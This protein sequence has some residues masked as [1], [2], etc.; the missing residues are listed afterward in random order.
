LWAQAGQYGNVGTATGT[1]PI[2]P[3]VSDTNP[4]HYFGSSPAINIDKVTNGSDGLYIHTG[5]PVTWTY[6]VTNTGNVPLSN[7]KVTD[8]KGVTPVYQSGDTNGDGKLDLTETWIYEASGT[9]IAGQYNNT[10]FTEGTGPAQRQGHR[11]GRLELLRLE[12]VHQH[13]QGHLRRRR[14]RRRHPDPFG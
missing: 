1:P 6:T 9:A 7:V 2:G 4:S 12:P 14:L 8:S 11:P 10:G 5:D 3:D 13:R